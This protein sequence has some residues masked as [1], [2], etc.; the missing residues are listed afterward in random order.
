MSF[1]NQ[2]GLHTQ[3]TGGGV[4]KEWELLTHVSTSPLPSTAQVVIF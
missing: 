2:S 3:N 4:T 1:I